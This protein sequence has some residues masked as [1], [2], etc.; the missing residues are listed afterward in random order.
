MF[1]ALAAGEG[2][3]GDIAGDMDSDEDEGDLIPQDSKVASQITLLNQ[4]S[5]EDDARTITNVTMIENEP[6]EEPEGD[7]LQRWLDETMGRTIQQRDTLSS[8]F[9]GEL[10]RHG[11]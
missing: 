5:L 1:R 8:R 11:H 7:A 2:D 6:K 3:P 9:T 4:R 10:Q